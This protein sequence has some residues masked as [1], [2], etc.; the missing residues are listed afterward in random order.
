MKK[1]KR[2]RKE[3]EKETHSHRKH[4]LSSGTYILSSPSSAVIPES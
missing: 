1:K 4:C 3:N 2:K